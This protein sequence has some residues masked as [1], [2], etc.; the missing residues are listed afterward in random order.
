MV[1]D[2]GEDQGGQLT[3]G[4][5]IIF[6]KGLAVVCKSVNQLPWR[7][8]RRGWRRVGVH[9]TQCAGDLS[10]DGVDVIIQSLEGKDLEL[11]LL[12]GEEAQHSG[13]RH[14]AGHVFGCRGGR[15]V[16]DVDCGGDG[17][18]RVKKETPCENGGRS[19]KRDGWDAGGDGSVIVQV[20]KVL[21]V[22]ASASGS[23]W[24][25]AGTGIHVRTCLPACLAHEGWELAELTPA[26]RLMPIM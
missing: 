26:A 8:D 19:L 9:L 14:E 5:R 1:V 15:L 6:V 23:R 17:E 3:L 10:P 4:E 18:V 12:V 21:S 25:G 2:L 11:W 20:L 22:G 24:P 7:E 13:S 16:A